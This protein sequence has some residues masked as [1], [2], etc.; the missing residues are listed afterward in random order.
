MGKGCCPYCLAVV[1]PTAAQI[2]AAERAIVPA[3]DRAPGAS[4]GDPVY[5][6]RCPACAAPLIATPGRRWAEVDPAAVR[7][8]RELTPPRTSGGSCKGA[9]AG[10]NQL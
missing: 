5:R 1:R 9:R 8:S 10:P 3:D 2:R 4:R 6:T 7:W